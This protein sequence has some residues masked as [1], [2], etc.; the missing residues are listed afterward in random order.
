MTTKETKLQSLVTALGTALF[1]SWCLVLGPVGALLLLGAAYAMMI[2]NLGLGAIC[3]ALAFFPAILAMIWAP[4]VFAT[5]FQDRHG[6][7]RIGH[8]FLSSEKSGMVGSSV[9]EKELS[10]AE[11]ILT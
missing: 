5:V 6:S 1:I 7:S 9:G 2:Q 4:L 10:R 3:I 11:E 8:G